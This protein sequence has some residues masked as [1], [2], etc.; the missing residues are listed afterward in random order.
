MTGGVAMNSVANGKITT[1][2]PFENV[3]IP[4][5]AADNGTSFGAAFHVW[6]RHLNQPRSFVQDHAIGVVKARTTNA[7]RLLNNRDLSTQGWRMMK[8]GRASIGLAD[9]W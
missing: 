2:T 5:G 3:Y 7:K 6:N 8:S 4:A 9:R 1:L